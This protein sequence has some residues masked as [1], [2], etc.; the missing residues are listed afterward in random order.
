MPWQIS[1]LH[2][3]SWVVSKFR[4]FGPPG[5]WA[6]LLRS[7]HF[8]KINTS[9]NL[10]AF[11]SHPS[12]MV[13]LI[14]VLSAAALS[15]LDAAFPKLMRALCCPIHCFP[16]VQSNADAVAQAFIVGREELANQPTTC[17]RPAPPLGNPGPKRL[18]ALDSCG[19]TEPCPTSSS[20]T[21]TG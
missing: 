10:L 3:L 8:S 19:G 6:S 2:G 7:Q 11:P 17:P 5:A 13:C 18:G 21:C 20:P 14:I 1:G 4:S 12:T 16:R 9:S 15:Q